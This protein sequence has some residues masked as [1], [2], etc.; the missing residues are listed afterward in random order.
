MSK[1]PTL[2]I[3]FNRYS[4]AG[5]CPI[6]G[7]WYDAHDGP[8]LFLEATWSP[9]CPRCGEQYAPALMKTLEQLTNWDWKRELDPDL[10]PQ[11]DK[12]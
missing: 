11:D 10:L 9:V 6:C 8:E 4:E 5:I 12:Q 7:Q 2:C 3:K 1:V